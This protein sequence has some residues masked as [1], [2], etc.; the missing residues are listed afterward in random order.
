MDR[1]ETSVTVPSTEASTPLLAHG[2]K[3]AHSNGT[4]GRSRDRDGSE[5]VDPDSLSKALQD[6][7]EAGSTREHTPSGSPSRKR[8]R[9]YGDR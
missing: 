8:Q 9:I 4:M 3:R 7:K 2:A 6:F 1:K 5:A